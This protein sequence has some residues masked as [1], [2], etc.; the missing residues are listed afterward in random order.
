MVQV[1]YEVFFIWTH[2]EKELHKCIEDLNNYQPNIKIIYIFSKTCVYFLDLRVHLSK[3]KIITNLHIK[4]TDRPQR[5]HFLLS[6]SNQAP[7]ISRISFK[8]YYFR[9]HFFEKK[10]WFLWQGCPK[11]LVQS[12]MKNYTQTTKF[13][14]C[15][16]PGPMVSFLILLPLPS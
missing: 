7:T 5:L 1:I 14:E 6:R 15:F 9:K 12:E 4:S 3:C 11:K 13:E 8:E 16:F 10:T 2:R